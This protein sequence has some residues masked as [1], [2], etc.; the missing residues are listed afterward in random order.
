M[1]NCAFSG[2][3]SFWRF[4]NLFLPSFRSHPFT[5]LFW[6]FLGLKSIEM[7][8]Y[9][10]DG[11]WIVSDNLPTL[12]KRIK[13]NFLPILTISGTWYPYFGSLFTYHQS[14]EVSLKLILSMVVLDHIFFQD[15]LGVIGGGLG[16]EM[17]RLA[18]SSCWALLQSHLIKNFPPYFLLIWPS[19]ATF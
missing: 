4:L 18:G 11:T 5:A 12:Q 1:Q 15:S 14:V 7:C 6:A 19:L 2:L 3:L 9:E 10:A 17:T 16:K 13:N 8:P